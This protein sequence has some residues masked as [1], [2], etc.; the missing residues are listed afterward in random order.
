MATRRGRQRPRVVTRPVLSR[1]RRNPHPMRPCHAAPIAL[2]SLPCDCARLLR[3]RRPPAAGHGTPPA[4]LKCPC[5]AGALMSRTVSFRSDRDRRLKLGSERGRHVTMADAGRAAADFIGKRTAGASP[6]AGHG[7]SGKTT[8]A[9]NAAYVDDGSGVASRPSLR[10]RC[11]A[12]HL[13]APRP[14]GPPSRR[15]PAALQG[16][17]ARRHAAP[18]HACMHAGRPSLAPAL[19]RT[20]GPGAP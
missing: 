1:A 15:P 8:S 14:G 19:Y 16:R 17:P 7:I 9:V 10:A 4:A 18:V 2:A 13:H 11:A 20:R 12:R 6:A 5:V 3:A